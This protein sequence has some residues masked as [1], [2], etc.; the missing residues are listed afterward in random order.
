M[1]RG[2]RPVGLKTIIDLLKPKRIL[3]TL[4]V[5][6]TLMP[7]AAGTIFLS[8]VTMTDS[9]VPKVDYEQVNKNGKSTTATITKIAS[10]Q[11][12]TINNEHPSIISY[13]YTNGSEE[14]E[15][16]YRALD[17][18]KIRKLNVG[19]TIE[20]KYLSSSSIIPG[21]E[22]VEF[23]LGLLLSIL[24]PFLAIGLGLLISLYLSVRKKI[25]LYQYGEIRDAEIIS[26][27]PTKSLQI[28]GIVQGLTIHYQ[29]N[30]TRG[31]SILGESFINDYSLL[32]SKKQGDFVK[33]FVSTDDESKSCLISKLD[34]VRNHWKIE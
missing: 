34:Q 29:Y 18:D 33:I 27:V 6:S 30:T 15:T 4:G 9:D 22:P 17:V 3:L 13:K 19:D 25:G 31:Q 5:A 24:I 11:N 16:R 7:L 1:N 21:L 8:L 12:V 20:V 26:M 28:S 23:A 14:I 10:Q 32:N 2:P